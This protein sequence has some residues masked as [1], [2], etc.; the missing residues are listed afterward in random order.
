MS[1][2]APRLIKPRANCF[3]CHGLGFELYADSFDRDNGRPCYVCEGRAKKMGAKLINL[4][5]R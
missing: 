5:P 3:N 1:K 4:Y 2:R